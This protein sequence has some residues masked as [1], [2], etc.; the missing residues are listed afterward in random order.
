VSFSD[1]SPVPE[2]VKSLIKK[3]VLS[4][5]KHGPELCTSGDIEITQLPLKP[6][7]IAAVA[8]TFIY[9]Y[10]YILRVTVGC[11]YA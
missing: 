11:V 2:P 9:I 7:E 5:S 4:G 1:K 8:F 10:I 6:F 3:L